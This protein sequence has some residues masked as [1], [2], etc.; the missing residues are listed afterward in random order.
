MFMLAG[1]MTPSLFTA[2]SSEDVSSAPASHDVVLA[3]TAAATTNSEM[4]LQLPEGSTQS[5]LQINLLVKNTSPDVFQIDEIQPDLEIYDRASMSWSI[6]AVVLQYEAAP[7][8]ENTAFRLDLTVTNPGIFAYNGPIFLRVHSL[9]DQDLT[10]FAL[11][12]DDGQTSVPTEPPVN[13]LNETQRSIGIPGQAQAQ[14]QTSSLYSVD[15]SAETD[16]HP[17]VPAFSS[18]LNVDAMMPTLGELPAGL[19]IVN[20]GKLTQSA[21]ASTFTDPVMADRFMNDWGW[22]ENAHMYLEGA[23]TADG[24]IYVDVGLHRFS[25]ET[26]ALLA[27]DYYV[28]G[29]AEVMGMWEIDDVEYGNH[30]RTITN[31]TDTTAYVVVDSVVARISVAGTDPSPHAIQ[32]RQLVVS[33][34]YGQS[35]SGWQLWRGLGSDTSEYAHLNQSRI[36]QS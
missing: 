17:A 14:V 28:A 2:Q 24:L 33:K 18:P 16:A 8:I 22:Q 5:S 34:G 26:S 1:G 32:I 6:E 35:S 12:F 15:L 11:Q 19:W 30:G 23:P 25:S 21:I 31:G 13:P 3:E 27:L 10:V 36:S 29:R 9:L 7:I 4:T 20:Q